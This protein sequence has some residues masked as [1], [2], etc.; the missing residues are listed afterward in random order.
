MTIPAY[1]LQWPA[2]WRRTDPADR[3]AARFAKK[4]RESYRRGDGSTSSWLRSRDPS[5]AEAR[6]AL[7]AV[8]GGAK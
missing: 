7:A 5:I 1:P 8:R 2:G 4:E 6:A 3:G